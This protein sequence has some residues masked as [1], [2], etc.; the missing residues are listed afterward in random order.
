[1]RFVSAL[2]VSGLMKLDRSQLKVEE[3][4]S[5]KKMNILS[6]A[7]AAVLDRGSGFEKQRKRTLQAAKYHSPLVHV[8]GRQI[9]VD[10]WI[11][12]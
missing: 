1:M 2:S 4:Q 5:Q 6:T 9:G 3:D 8:W 11:M 7:Q 12:C 10:V